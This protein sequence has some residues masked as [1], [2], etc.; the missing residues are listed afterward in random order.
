[1]RPSGRSCIWSPYAV[2]RG[3]SLRPRCLTRSPPRPTPHGPGPQQTLVQVGVWCLGEYADLLLSGGEGENVSPKEVLDMLERV[4]RD[5]TTTLPTKEYVLSAL[6]KCGARYANQPE[7][8]RVSQLLAPFNTSIALELQQRAVEYSTLANLAN[9]RAGVLERMPALEKKQKPA[10]SMDAGLGG[11]NGSSRAAAEP[12][13]AAQPQ[14]DANLLMDLLDDSAPSTP[15]LGVGAGP[16]PPAGGG[17]GDL[18]SLIGG[19]DD[20]IG[21]AAT[22]PTPPPAAPAPMGGMDLMGGGAA[23]VP[24]A[25]AAPE[26]FVV[27]EKGGLCIRFALSK[28]PSNPSVSA[29][30]ASFS[31][32][33][34]SPLT[35]LVFQA[36]VPKYMKMQIQPA[37]GNMVPPANSGTVKQQI[38][39]AN[40]MHGQKNIAMRIKVEYSIDGNKVAETGEVSNFPPGF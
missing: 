37:T 11:Q 13:K 10:A 38:K 7:A 29:V 40:S 18:N 14:S 17:G 32:A 6:V 9:I 1:M 24:A 35:D 12:A 26:P 19:L 5:V 3:P 28:D 23:A 34:A 8:A 15:G 31:N 39:L 33:N 21:G 20:L 4:L 22:A 25:P 27:F 36:A 30:E 2:V 16:A